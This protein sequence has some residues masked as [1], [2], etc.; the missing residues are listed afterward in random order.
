MIY[1]SPGFWPSIGSPDLSAYVLWVAH[2]GTTCPSMPTGWCDLAFHQIR[3]R[4]RCPALPAASTPTCSTAIKA[5]LDAIASNGTPPVVDM[6]GAPP[7]LAGGSSGGAD[8]A[9]AGG[10]AGGGGGGGDGDG[11]QRRHGGKGD[12]PTPAMPHGCSMAARGALPASARRP[13]FAFVLGLQL[14]Q[15][16]PEAPPPA[17][18]ARRSAPAATSARARRRRTRRTARAGRR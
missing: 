4:A 18:A 14:N 12:Q 1:T 2:W 11:R 6:G 5:A 9:A 10:G 7:D 16:R 13:S 8:M 15:A 3:T 17:R